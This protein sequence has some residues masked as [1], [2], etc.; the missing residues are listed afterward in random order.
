MS[1]EGF[2]N[3]TN[4]SLVMIGRPA[5]KSIAKDFCFGAALQCCSSAWQLWLTNT[6]DAKR[7]RLIRL[8]QYQR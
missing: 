1:I 4:T 3:N 5:A 2:Q 7:S 8:K 6:H